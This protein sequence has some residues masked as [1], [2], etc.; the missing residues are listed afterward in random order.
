MWYQ[1]IPLIKP[2]KDYTGST[3]KGA[4]PVAI[5][6]IHRQSYTHGRTCR[7]FMPIFI[8]DQPFGIT[9]IARFMYG[10]NTRRR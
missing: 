5:Q 9:Y 10:P 4:G 3:P 6:G 1:K 2:N 7:F 8:G